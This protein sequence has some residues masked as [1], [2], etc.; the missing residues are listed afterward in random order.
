MTKIDF[1]KK[2][3]NEIHTSIIAT[4]DEEMK[5]V[6]CVIDIM[7]FDDNGLYFLT[8]KGKSFYTRLIKQGNLAMTLLK[9]KDTMSSLSIN[10]KAEVKDIGCDKID[11]YFKKINI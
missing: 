11:F 2:I 1:F 4:V 5:P 8:A 10:I 9:G 3:V 6:T 7:D